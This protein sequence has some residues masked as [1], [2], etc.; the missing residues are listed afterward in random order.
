MSI[1]GDYGYFMGMAATFMNN[2]NE[3]QNEWQDRLRKRMGAD[4]I[5]F[6]TP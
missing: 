5:L 4:Q 1:F 2:L 6:Y 3:Q